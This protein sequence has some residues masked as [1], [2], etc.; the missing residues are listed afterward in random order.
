MERNNVRKVT[1][2]ALGA[3]AVVAMTVALFPITANATEPESSEQSQTTVQTTKGV[4]ATDETGASYASFAEAVEKAKDGST[5]TLEA[6][7]A[8]NVT[9]DKKITVTAASANIVYTGT[10]RINASDVTVTALSFKLDPA[11]STNGQSVIVSAAAQGV[12]ITKNN[13][14]IAAGDPETGASKNKDWQPSSV[15]LEQGADNTVISDNTFQLGQVKNNS[16]VGV[17]L[18][19]SANSI[20]DTVIK[21]NTVTTGPTT[22]DGSDGTMM[23]VVAN[24]NLDPN[25]SQY[26]VKNLTVEGNTVDGMAKPDKSFGVNIGDVNGM[27]VNGNTFI[28]NYMGLGYSAWQGS[29][30]NSTGLTVRSNTFSDNTASVYLGSKVTA[31]DITYGEDEQANVYQQTTGYTAKSP[32]APVG[33]AFVGWYSDKNLTVLAKEGDQTTYAKYIPVGQVVTK[34]D[35][36]GGSLKIKDGSNYSKANLRF[37]YNVQLADGLTLTGWKFGYYSA[38]GSLKRSVTGVN[39]INASEYDPAMSGEITNL[40]ITDVPSSA[41]GE[42]LGSTLIVTGYKTPDGAEVTRNS[43]FASTEKQTRSVKQVCESVQKDSN[44]SNELKEYAGNLLA[45]MK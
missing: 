28:K 26:G 18:V 22:G 31:G 2:S 11:T 44:A 20:D 23:F 15:W 19:G 13:F 35:F 3:V 1:G 33:L 8:E 42:N 45:Q 25:T 6:N 21:N 37:G 17:N 41:Y 39:K 43:G 38:D 4:A 10:M 12:R 5:V 9:I 30:V 16:A 7:N 29:Q 40:V 14:T 34:L 27:T 24:G 32:I 36:L